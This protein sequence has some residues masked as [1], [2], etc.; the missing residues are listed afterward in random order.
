MLHMVQML[1]VLMRK[2]SCDVLASDS[3]A[4]SDPGYTPPTYEGVQIRRAGTHLI[5][6]R[7]RFFVCRARIDIG[8]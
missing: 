1:F 2:G 5:G 3:T 8:T 7:I 4:V 6:K